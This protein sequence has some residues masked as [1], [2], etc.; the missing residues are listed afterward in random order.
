VTRIKAC[1]PLA[2]P[3]LN[4]CQPLVSIELSFSYQ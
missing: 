4:P 3:L 1:Q 2:R